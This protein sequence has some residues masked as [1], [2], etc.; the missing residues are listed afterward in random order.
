[1]KKLLA[2]LFALIVGCSMSF[3][4]PSV[5]P[6]VQGAQLQA[7]QFVPGDQSKMERKHK[8]RHHRHGRK[9]PSREASSL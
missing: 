8:K 1:M 5:G 2:L 7:G 4:Q 3:A 6:M 9:H